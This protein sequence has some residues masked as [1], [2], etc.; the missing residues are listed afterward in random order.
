MRL[1]SN[2]VVMF[3]FTSPVMAAAD[4]QEMVE[5]AKRDLSTPVQG[6]PG[7]SFGE[8][9]KQA[10]KRKVGASYSRIQASV[11]ADESF[12]Q[13]LK[14]VTRER[15]ARSRNSHRSKGK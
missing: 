10:V 7:P 12:G 4:L 15:A 2:I 8:K 5:Q 9:L 1:G 14:R 13:K 6:P 3:K 11:P